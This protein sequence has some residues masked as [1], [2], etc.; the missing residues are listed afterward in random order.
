MEDKLIY[1]YLYLVIILSS[2]HGKPILSTS[3]GKFAVLGKRYSIG[4]E[5]DNTSTSLALT[6]DGNIE[7]EVERR[8]C[9]GTHTVKNYLIQ[10]NTS[11]D[12]TVTIQAKDVTHNLDNT[13]WQCSDK[14]SQSPPFLLRVYTPP[15][16]G[17]IT[18]IKGGNRPF[19]FGDVVTHLCTVIG[20]FPKPRLMWNSLNPFASRE[21]YYD[22]KTRRNILEIQIN[23]SKSYHYYDC[24]CFAEH[25]AW[26][27]PMDN[28]SIPVLIQTAPIIGINNRSLYTAGPGMPVTITLDYYAYPGNTSVILIKKDNTDI[29]SENI[30]KRRYVKN[31]VDFTAQGQRY[32]Y[33]GESVYWTLGMFNETDY[34]PYKIVLQNGEGITRFA[35]NITFQGPPSEPYNVSIRDITSYG[36]TVTFSP[37]YNGGNE[38]TFCISHWPSNDHKRKRNVKSKKEPIKVDNMFSSTD[39]QFILYAENKMGRSLASQKDPLK[40]RTTIGEARDGSHKLIHIV[41]FVVSVCLLLIL[42]AF[43]SAIVFCYKQKTFTRELPPYIPPRATL[44]TNRAVYT[45]RAVFRRSVG[46]PD[47]ETVDR[48][49]SRCKRIRRAIKVPPILAVFRKSRYLPDCNVISDVHEAISRST[50]NIPNGNSQATSRASDEQQQVRQ[51][52]ATFP[53]ELNYPHIEI[54]HQGP[55]TSPALHRTRT[56]YSQIYFNDRISAVPESIDVEEDGD[57][58]NYGQIFFQTA[59]LPPRAAK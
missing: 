29:Q 14:I 34:G 17:P 6:K 35:L 46:L 30:T 1:C 3:P 55:R 23:I 31:N 21:E 22:D 16:N 4:C 43:I 50:S 59:T 26:S 54:R 20:G 37:G 5:Y 18:E 52:A 51:S 10:C 24:T 9:S 28:I 45:D 12:L 36:F 7:V 56:N 11:G 42:T 48:M 32:Q 41:Y 40:I 25:E 38:Q 2:C 44:N 58:G 15:T 33:E 47:S 8:T 57:S 13:T 19:K 53:R 39:Y 27:G 49:T